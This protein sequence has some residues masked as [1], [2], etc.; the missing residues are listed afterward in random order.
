MDKELKDLYEVEREGEYKLVIRPIEE[1]LEEDL[2]EDIDNKEEE[3]EPTGIMEMEVDMSL[4]KAMESAEESGTLAEFI[5]DYIAFDGTIDDLRAAAGL[6]KIVTIDILNAAYQSLLDGSLV[7]DDAPIDA[8]VDPYDYLMKIVVKN[9]LF[10]DKEIKDMV[11]DEY[12]FHMGEK[13]WDD[14]YVRFLDD[15]NSTTRDE[16]VYRLSRLHEGLEDTADIDVEE[17]EVE[18]DTDDEYEVISI[19]ELMAELKAEDTFDTDKLE[20]EKKLFKRYA[21]ILGVENYENLVMFYDADFGYLPA[22]HFDPEEVVGEIVEL[23]DN[24]K[25]MAVTYFE[26][27]PVV[28]EENYRTGDNTLFFPNRN[29]AIKYLKEIDGI[30][31]EIEDNEEGESDFIADTMAD[32]EITNIEEALNMIDMRNNNKYDLLNKYLSEDITTEQRTIIK[33]MLKEGADDEELSKVFTY[34]P[35]DDSEEAYDFM[36]ANGNLEENEYNLDLCKKVI[37]MLENARFELYNITQANSAYKAATDKK[38]QIISVL[39]EAI[40]IVRDLRTSN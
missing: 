28:Y 39:E 6:S 15:F 20:S 26:S 16:L 31:S 30:T 40:A 36:K 34:N 9:K 33:K 38:A 17:G 21:S 7:D 23:E 1:D 22:D 3:G 14:A 11:F 5:A 10:N 19:G 29:K 2:I 8:E 13:A 4:V 32:M 18:E 25:E 37:P 27:I 12:I 35:D 24:D